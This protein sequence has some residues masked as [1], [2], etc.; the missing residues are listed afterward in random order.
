MRES[1]FQT[2]FSKWVKH[3]Y[4]KSAAFELK[5]TK[6]KSLPFDAVQPH[7]LQALKNAKHT[8]LFYKIP[9]AG[10][11]QKPFDCFSLSGVPTYVVVMFYT[12]G[13]KTF[14]MID[15]DDF[16]AASKSSKRRSLLEEVAERIGQKYLLS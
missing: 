5:L 4:K 14:Y 12:R 11:S 13:C 8:Q 2:R 15:V 16:E 7:Q 10:F 3:V 9:D 1:I 6:S